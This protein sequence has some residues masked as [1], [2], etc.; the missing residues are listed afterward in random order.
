MENI[1]YN[2]RLWKMEIYKGKKVTTYTVRWRVADRAFKEPF[3]NN[4]AQALSFESA[5]RTAASKGEAFD[6][7][8]GRPVSWGR[9]T[10][11]KPWYEFCVEYVD[12]KWKHASPKHRHNI[13]WALI[14]AMPAMLATERGKPAEKVI[15]QVLRKWGFNTKHRELCPD[16]A[17]G[18][19]T[20]LAKNTRPVSALADPRTIRAVLDASTT[21]VDGQRAAPST[22][23][24]HRAILSNACEYAV[25]LGLL[26]RNPVKAIKRTTP[27]TAGEVDQ[28]SV[29]NHAQ[30][31]RLLSAV[32]A[33]EPSGPRLVAFFATMYYAGLRPEEV[34]QLHRDNVMLPD[35]VWDE[36]SEDWKEPAND[37]G[38]LRFCSAAPELDGAWTDKGERREGRQLK[39]RAAGDWRTVP[40]PPPLTHL[41]RAHLQEIGPDRAGRMFWGVRDRGNGLP[42]VTYRR[43]WKRAREKALTASEFRS[44]LAQRPYDLR[45]ACVSTWLNSGVPVTQVAEWA[46]HSVQVL[47]RVYAK[48]IAGQDEAAKR[49]IEIALRE[50]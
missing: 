15:R 42:A 35:L 7:T 50:S 4:K 13:A 29:V 48:C 43:S 21:R 45:H 2:V 37:W 9:P 10:G 22:A 20:W 44:P 38:E 16:E 34:V 41:L 17:A 26:H 24:R 27:M 8:T 14:Y 3:R 19:L 1:S 6:T 49:R 28:R 40:T 25:E 36:A 11:D 32:R 31:R 39:A 46:G 23:Q 30:A 47:L 33:Q 5:L 18:V 12:M